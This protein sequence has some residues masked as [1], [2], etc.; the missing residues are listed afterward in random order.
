M[1]KIVLLLI[2]AV[3][4]GLF[5]FINQKG[6]EIFQKKEPPDLGGFYKLTREDPLFYSPFFDGEEF[7]RAIKGLE[8]SENQLKK[9]LIENSEAT[10]YKKD[11]IPILKENNLFPYQ[12]LG[13]LILI[14]QKTEEFFQNPS[15]EHGKDLLT[16]YDIAAD[17]YIQ[18]IS[19]K[20]KILETIEYTTNRPYFFILADSVSSSE[21]I[22]NDFL[23]IKENGY[24]L[25][26]EIAKRRNCLLGKE[27]CEPLLKTKDNASFMDLMEGGEFNLEGEKIDFIKSMIESI[28]ANSSDSLD[29]EKELRGPYKIKSFCWQNPDFEHWMYLLYYKQ[30]DKT[31]VL[32]KLANQNYYFKTP[33]KSPS[34]VYEALFEKGLKFTFQAEATTYGCTDLTFYPQLLTLD[35]LKKQIEKGLIAKEDLEENLDYKL[36]I[37]NQFG[38]MVPVINTIS[39]HLEGPKLYQMVDK[40]PISPEFLFLTR[41]AYS[42]FYFPF[43]KSIW[44]V[45]KELKY[46]VPEEKKPLIG[47]INFAVFVTLDELEK[48][49]YTKTEI[50]KFYVNII[51]FRYSFLENQP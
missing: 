37:E 39:S 5:V 21:V 12:F 3:C 10:G 4:L 42:I 25:K 51:E 8:E 2:L 16:L 19:S 28:L 48:L 13:N 24:K 7:K 9:V 22:K 40:L 34:K 46:F 20:I 50:K 18:D 15:V 33:S 32:P 23:T 47:S 11:Y 35:F 36:L 31:L 49:G 29:Q 44:R 45:D 27:D 14:N 41:T 26:E 30:G 17:S 1:R 6:R 38:L 43:A